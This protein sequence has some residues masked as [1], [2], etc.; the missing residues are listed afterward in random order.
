MLLGASQPGESLREGS[1]HGHK[2]D[3][4]G[5]VLHGSLVSWVNHNDQPEASQTICVGLTGGAPVEVDTTGREDE[6]AGSHARRLA[7]CDDPH[8]A[9][10]GLL[11]AST[12][13]E[14]C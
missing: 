3:H 5:D 8:G 1:R 12:R 7:L 14:L 4:T 11:A 6:E 10:P 13:Q 9:V 2:S